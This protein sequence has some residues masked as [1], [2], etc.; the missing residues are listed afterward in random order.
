MKNEEF[1]YAMQARRMANSSFFIP[2]SSF[3]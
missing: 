1:G 2:H 3:P